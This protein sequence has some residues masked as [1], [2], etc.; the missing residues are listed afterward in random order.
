MRKVI[1]FTKISI[2]IVLFSSCSDWFEVTSGSEVREEDHYNSVAGFR[3]SLTGCYLGMTGEALYG[4]NLSWCGIEILAHQFYPVTL[5]GGALDYRL[6]EFN[7]SHSD[8]VSY[9]EETW[10]KAYNVIVNANNTL[11]WI[12]KKASLLDDIEYHVIKGELLAIRAY[13]HFDLLRLYGYG[14]WAGR[15]SELNTKVTVP[16]VTG[17]S[18]DAAAQ[19]SGAQTLQMILADLEEAAA[20]LKGYDPITGEHDASF[21]AQVNTDSYF[22]D[23]T[24]HLNYYAVKALQARVYLWEG[25]ETGKTKA[26]AAA[27]EVIA[28]IGENGINMSDMSTYCYPMPAS[29]ISSSNRSLAAENLFG[30]NVAS[31]STKTKQHLVPGYTDSDDAA[32]FLIPDDAYALYEN[33]SSDIRFSQLLSQSSLSTTRGF[34]PLK[35]YQGNLGGFFKDK[36]PMI[37]LPEVYYIAAECLVSTGNSNPEKAMERLNFIRKLRGL[38]SDLEK[39][40]AD[41]IKNEI[42]KEYKK[43]FLSEGIMFFYYKRTGNK[44]IPHYN[45]EMSDDGYVLPYPNFE[46]QSGRI[47]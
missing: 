11:I 13:L 6:Q 21:Y 25:S 39:L 43:E 12:D 36:L 19:L 34:V 31:L 42:T 44:N 32:M 24:L 5:S 7:Y 14:N 1:L 28:A 23:R 45:K 8:A 4:K 9:V 26:L 33:S 3:Q 15:A 47:Q 18:K 16:Y 17:V 29:T 35:A 20:L 40:S 41:E 38:Y 46:L 27:E 10:A 30:L 2:L 22:N 37:R